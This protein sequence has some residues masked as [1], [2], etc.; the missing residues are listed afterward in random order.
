MSSPGEFHTDTA[1]MPV[2]DGRFTA[3]IS[4]RWSV[5][6]GA[7]GG[8]VSAMLAQA[9]IAAERAT[10]DDARHLRSLTVHLL[11]PALPGPA[12]L[13][14]AVRRDGRSAT[15][16]DA[17][18]AAEDR[19][20]AIA[21]G[22]VAADRE[23]GP[24]HIDHPAPDFPPPEA[25]GSEA[26]PDPLMIR[27]RYDTRYTVGGFPPQDLDRAEVSGWIRPAD[28][29]PVDLPLL[30]ALLDA[31]PPPVMMLPGPLMMASTIDI[32][33]HLFATLDDPL[34]DFVAMTNTSKINAGGY[35]DTE[36]EA[37]TRDGR[38]LGQARQ[39]SALM[40]GEPLPSPEG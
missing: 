6:P 7:N 38:L 17:E 11:R 30:V 31:W 21:R 24:D 32:T 39:L 26:W 15:V 33:Y 37:W 4:D 12:T 27:S 28:H 18:L 34:D 36:T 29:T 9:A 2:G 40:P 19:L 3:T 8:Y 16:V 5:G 10:H 1:L 25:L 20:V 23:A 35:V 14:T 13:T 22:V